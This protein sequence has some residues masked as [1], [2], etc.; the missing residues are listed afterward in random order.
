MDTADLAL[1]DASALPSDG[2]DLPACWGWNL[3]PAEELGV[4]CIIYCK[5]E[6]LP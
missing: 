5:T 6:S 4:V 3:K 2:Q 1:N